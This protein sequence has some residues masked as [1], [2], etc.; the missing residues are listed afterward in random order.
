MFVMYS[1]TPIGDKIPT[2]GEFLVVWGALFLIVVLYI[3]RK[4]R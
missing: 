4:I 3:D 1:I 2:C